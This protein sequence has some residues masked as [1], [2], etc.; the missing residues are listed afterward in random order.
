MTP[1]EA[2]RQVRRQ[3]RRDGVCVGCGR[4]RDDAGLLCCRKCRGFTGKRPPRPH[5]IN[6]PKWSAVDHSQRRCRCGLRLPCNDCLPTRADGSRR[7]AWDV[8]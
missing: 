7:V 6:S 2:R 1:A 5:G 4:A 8:L 3:W